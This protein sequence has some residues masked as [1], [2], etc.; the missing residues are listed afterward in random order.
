MVRFA[1]KSL[2]QYTLTQDRS[3]EESL[4]E[5]HAAKEFE[6]KREIFVGR[7]VMLLNERHW[8]FI[9]PKTIEH[10]GACFGYDEDRREVKTLKGTSQVPKKYNAEFV[11]VFPDDQNGL[12]KITYFSTDRNELR[13][14]RQRMIELAMHDRTIVFLSGDDLGRMQNAFEVEFCQEE[15]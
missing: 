7:V 4:T 8:G 10:P 9:C 5:N 12:E 3:M 14:F 1:E 13:R 11:D 6:D 15:D 2:R